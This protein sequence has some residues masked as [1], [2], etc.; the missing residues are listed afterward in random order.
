MYSNTGQR[1]NLAFAYGIHALCVIAYQYKIDFSSVSVC[2][3]LDLIVFHAPPAVR[4]VLLIL[5]RTE[6]TVSTS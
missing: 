4:D 3:G 1:D 6:S 5:L 2:R